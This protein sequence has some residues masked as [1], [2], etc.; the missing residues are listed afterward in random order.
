MKK[1]LFILFIFTQVSFSKVGTFLYT[2]NTRCV[3]NVIPN[4]NDKG[5]CYEYSSN[6]GTQYCTKKA[7]LSHFIRGYIFESNTCRIEDDLKLT[8][9]TKDEY[10]YIIIFIAISFVLVF[11]TILFMLIT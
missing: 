11:F 2:K 9:M 3:E 6:L 8:G 4:P 10:N 7:K 1:L 5:F